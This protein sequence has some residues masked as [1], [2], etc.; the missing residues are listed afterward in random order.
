MNDAAGLQA[1]FERIARTRMHDM[2]LQNPAL[3][4]QAV[5]FR[6]WQA[7][8]VGVLITP[9][10]INLVVLPGSGESSWRFPSGDYVAMSGAEE[11]C[12]RYEFASLS[13]PPM[14]L[15]NQ[16]RAVA[17][18]EAVME[19]L[20]ASGSTTGTTRQPVPAT[21]GRRSLFIPP[22]VDGSRVTE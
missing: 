13:S 14:E 3:R 9:W 19:Q 16:D 2:P 18:A 7:G 11:E 20:F 4:V 15:E 22:D 10:S 5:G 17:F 21:I 12:G 8:W 6:P 1:A